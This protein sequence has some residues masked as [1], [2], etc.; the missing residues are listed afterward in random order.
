MDRRVIAH[1]DLDAFYASVELL[2]NPALKGKPVIV[3]GSGPRA[4]VTTATYEARAF[5]VRSAMP[6]SQ[7]RRLC[8][9]ATLIPPDFPAYREASQRVWALVREHVATVEQAG[10][11][12][13][14]LDLSESVAPKALMRRLVIAIQEATGLSASVGIGPNKLVAKIALGRREAGWPG[15]PQPRD[16]LRAL[17]RRARVCCPA[18]GP[19][20]PSACRGWGSRRSRSCGQRTRTSFAAPSAT[21]SA[22]T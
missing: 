7:A 14:Y 19:R 11:D 12:E 6:T 3:S 17:R 2:R 15:R 9:D 4:V 18:S 10:I 21:T 1:L 20:R 5:G 16:G 22:A 8:P 13:G